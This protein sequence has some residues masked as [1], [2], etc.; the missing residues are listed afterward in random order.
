MSMDDM[1][2]P[3]GFTNLDENGPRL[4]GPPAARTWL[5]NV[6]QGVTPERAFDVLRDCAVPNQLRPVINT[7]DV[8]DARLTVAG[9]SIWRP[10]E[11]R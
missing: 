2:T 9:T 6:K 8:S 3:R 10:S 7:G 4:Y 11:R 5:G 1:I